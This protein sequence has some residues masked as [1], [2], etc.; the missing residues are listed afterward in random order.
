MFGR[1]RMEHQAPQT[2]SSH[3]SYSMPATASRFSSSGPPN[4]MNPSSGPPP[5][6]LSTPSTMSLP[7]GAASGLGA[8][9]SP[10]PGVTSRENFP[11]FGYGVTMPP[12][13][14]AVNASL[15]AL[16]AIGDDAR[17]RDGPSRDEPLRAEDAL[18]RGLG[19]R[20]LSSLIEQDKKINVGKDKDGIIKDRDGI[21]RLTDSTM[22]YQSPP[23][24]NVPLGFEGRDWETFPSLKDL[25]AAKEMDEK[26]KPGLGIGLIGGKRERD[27]DESSKG[28]K[29][30]RHHHHHQP[31]HPHPHHHLN[32]H[33]HHHDATS[34]LEATASVSLAARS[35][36]PHPHRHHHVLHHHHNPTAGFPS[37]LGVN[38]QQPQ[39]PLS[40]VTTTLLIDSSKVL[41]SLATKPR[42]YLGSMVYL[43]TP[44]PKTGYSV[45]QPLMPRFEGKENSIFQ[46]RIP[47]RFLSES[48]RR[49]ACRK[50]PVWGTDVYT[51]DSDVLGVL[52][53]TGKI[54]GVLPEGVEPSLVKDSGRK[55]V[56]RGDLSASST[57]E[58][59]WN[60]AG[61]KKTNEEPPPIPEMKDLVVNLLILPVLER[62]S[63]TVRHA[64]KSR[65]W[66][67]QHDGMSYFIWDLEWVDAGEAESRGGGNKKRR[68]NERE[69]VRKWGQLPPSQG[70]MGQKDGWNKGRWSMEKSN[71]D[72][73]G[74][75]VARVGA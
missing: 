58:A 74:G 37:H 21:M 6:S 70:G 27:D 67:G 19:H 47:K 5:V 49:E 3:T 40:K 36:S 20:S 51:D 71:G 42:N 59:K 4:G 11:Q 60:G 61:P 14:F 66:K 65:S 23:R 33:H 2:S 9:P 41:E 68:L 44:T 34:P 30:K 64:F 12:S 73:N 16:P 22:T 25:P 53:H 15:P 72:G 69:W 46:I 56:V 8:T 31:G 48:H 7:Q 13:P 62:Y 10:L 26:D 52:I 63:G 54:P 17:D 28:E 43:P 55:V 39:P 18:Q 32:H 29:K 35:K 1:E 75:E 24:R 50:R 38:V 57:P 45:T